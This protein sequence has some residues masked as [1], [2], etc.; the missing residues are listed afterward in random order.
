M[1]F[2]L[3]AFR[4]G[5]AA[6]T[7]WICLQ[8]L[9]ANLFVLKQVSLFG[10]YVTC[11]D[12]FAIGG[13]FSLNLL[14]EHYGKALAQQAV[15]L[16]FYFL[17]FFAILSQVHL[18]YRPAPVD[19]MHGA[20]T[21]LFTPVPRLLLASLATFFIVQKCD[22]KLFGWLK[23][24]LASSSFAL[25]TFCS[26]LISQALDTALFSFLGLYGIVASFFDVLLISFLLKAAIIFSLSPMTY[27]TRKW[28]QTKDLL[29]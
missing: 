9:L 29:P 10:F 5:K 21:Q 26:L 4:L 14:Q 12:V 15:Y 7:V 13:I 24:H 8:A 1:V 23:L 19:S 18:L 16:C 2:T 6:L 25:R 17:L 11:S 28:F 20:Y 3:A 22:I 27:F